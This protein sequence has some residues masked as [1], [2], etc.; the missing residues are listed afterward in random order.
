MLYDKNNSKK[1]LQFIFNPSWDLSKTSCSATNNL[2]V[3]VFPYYPRYTAVTAGWMGSYCKVSIFIFNVTFSSSYPH[4]LMPDID[5]R[6]ISFQSK[7]CAEICCLIL[8]IYLTQTK[9]FVWVQISVFWRQNTD[10]WWLSRYLDLM[11][12]LYAQYGRG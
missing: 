7:R 1:L 8:K 5:K 2:L 11:N 3:Q 9:I 6:P 10:I 12:S 4:K